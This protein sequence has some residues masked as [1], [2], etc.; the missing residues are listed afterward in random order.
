MPSHHAHRIILISKT[1]EEQLSRSKSATVEAEPAEDLPEV[2][3]TTVNA[4]PDQVSRQTKYSH[5]LAHKFRN[6]KIMQQS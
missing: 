5:T 1:E 4:L 2:D 6:G 3:E